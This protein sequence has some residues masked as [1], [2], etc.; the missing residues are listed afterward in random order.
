MRYCFLW[1]IED[2]YF[3]ELLLGIASMLA[4]W[5]FLNLYLLV[6]VKML[7]VQIVIF[8]CPANQVPIKSLALYT[9]ITRSNSLYNDYQIKMTNS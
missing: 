5:I 4:P 2:I 6:L 9:Y 8:D 7:V 1:R 3:V